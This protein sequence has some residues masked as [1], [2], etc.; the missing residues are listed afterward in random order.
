M[1]SCGATIKDYRESLN[2]PQRELAYKLD[3]DVAVLSRIENENR[4]PKKRALEIIKIAAQL[5]GIN[6][7]EL[8][9]SYLSDEIATILEY[10]QDYETILKVSER[11]VSYI[12]KN[13]N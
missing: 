6:E 8:R 3:I 7:E 11:K 4:F 2:W 10:E 9:N 13:K 1:K 12:R 5:F